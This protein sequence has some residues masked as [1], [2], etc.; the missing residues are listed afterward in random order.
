MCCGNDPRGH[1]SEPLVNICLS[2]IRKQ[3]TVLVCSLSLGEVSGPAASPGSLCL[4]HCTLMGMISRPVGSH[5]NARI[6][7]EK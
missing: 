2:H 6:C 7:V 5:L 1:T 4:S 3:E